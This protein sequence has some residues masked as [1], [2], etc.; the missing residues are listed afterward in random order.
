VRVSRERAA[1][2][3]MSPLGLSFVLPLVGPLISLASPAMV[4]WLGPA[5]WPEKRSRAWLGVLAFMAVWLPVLL[6]LLEPLSLDMFGLILPSVHFW[7]VIP[8]CGPGDVF[9]F[10]LPSVAALTVYTAGSAA[11]V[12]RGQAALWPLAALGATYTYTGAVRALEASGL[13]AFI[14]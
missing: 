3:L 6:R 12:R 11:S 4:K 14:C 13:G 2:I 8:L 10:V 9:S 1:V 7:T 5:V